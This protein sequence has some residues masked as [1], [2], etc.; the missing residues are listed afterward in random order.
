MDLELRRV[1]RDGDPARARRQVVAGQGALAALVE[2]ALRREGEGMRRDDEA[3]GEEF[4][5]HQNFPSRTAHL[6]GLPD[7]GSP[8]RSQS[9]CH[10][11][12]VPAGTVG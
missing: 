8:S 7:V 9:A 12:S 2:R 1:H 3:L 5:A 4:R 10:S 6:V 11:I